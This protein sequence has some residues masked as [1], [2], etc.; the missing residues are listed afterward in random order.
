MRKS[1]AIHS[2]IG[3]LGGLI[4]VGIELIWRGHSHWTMF[5]LGG[6]CFVLIGLINEVLPADTPLVLQMLCG[7]A[8]VT[9]AELLAGLVLNRWL[10]L[11]IWDY[12]DMPLNL[13]GQVC[14][15]YMAL[16]FALS[17][18]A[19]VLEDYL[20]YRWFGGEKPKYRWI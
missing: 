1:A 16:W 11:G 9:A 19:I 8:L 5:V 13:W 7:A 6:V 12:S 3:L 17:L 10:G 15:P 14:A 20:H 4:Y 18:P 2:A